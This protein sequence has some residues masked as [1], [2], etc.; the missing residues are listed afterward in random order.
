MK[1]L[2]LTLRHTKYNT[3]LAVGVVFGSAKGNLTL[4][5]F[6]FGNPSVPN[7]SAPGRLLPSAKGT[8]RFPI[9]PRL[10]PCLFNTKQKTPISGVFCLVAPRGIEPLFP[11]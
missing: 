6:A 8:S 2:A 9:P 5:P 7:S 4:T 11:G 3:R 10:I 1:N